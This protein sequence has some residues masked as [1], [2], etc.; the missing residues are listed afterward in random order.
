ML[1]CS[2]NTSSFDFCQKISLGWGGKSRMLRFMGIVGVLNLPVQM[3]SLQL[4]RRLR[5]WHSRD[6]L[7]GRASEWNSNGSEFC[8]LSGFSM[9]ESTDLENFFCFEGKTTIEILSDAWERTSQTGSSQKVRD[10]SLLHEFY[11]RVRQ[12]D[13]SESISCSRHWSAALMSDVRGKLS[14]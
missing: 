8:Q 7:C 12:M 9:L 13:V 4:T 6:T 14:E 11:Q 3:L 10:S 1:Q 2:S 5:C